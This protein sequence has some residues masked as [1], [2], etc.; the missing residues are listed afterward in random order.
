MRHI[1]KTDDSNRYMPSSLTETCPAP[2]P[3]V[4]NEIAGPRVLILTILHAIFPDGG[5]PIALTTPSAMD[6]ACRSYKIILYKYVL[7]MER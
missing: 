3:G 1:V 2:H 6:L 5:L 7:R 4:G